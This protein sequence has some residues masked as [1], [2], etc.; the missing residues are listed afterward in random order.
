[1]RN[2]LSDY[3]LLA[4]SANLKETALNSFQTLDTS[5][6][7][8]KDVVI[9]LEQRRED[10]ADEA[11]GKE[12][13]DT[14]YDLGALSGSSLSFNKAQ[15]QHFAFLYAFALGSIASSAYG[16]GYKHVM[17][18]TPAITNPSFTAAMR[19]G[20]TIM[21]I[22]FASMFVDTVKASFAKD[23][24]AKAEGGFKG[25]GKYEDNMFKETVTAAYNA[26][27]L[28][29][30]ANGV[31]GSDAATRL[32]NVHQIRVQVP[33]T[34][35]WKE[36]FYSV[37]SAATP[38][39]LT[40]SAPGGVATS[41]SYEILY[42]PTEPAWCTIPSRVTESPLKVHNLIIKFGGKWDGSAFQGGRTLD[43]EINSIEH[44]INNQTLI[45]FRPGGNGQYANYAMRQGRQQTLTLNREM[46][47][48]I[49]QQR[50][51]DNEYFGVQLKAIGEE[52]ETG[53]NFS[54]EMIF[55]R[56]NI[57]KAPVSING[58]VIAEAGDLK[59]LED[60]TYGSIRVEIANKVSG[61]AV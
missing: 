23:A 11:T 56:C 12:E 19:F 3:D 53:K 27:S 45:D 6:L 17:T 36:V 28:T 9:N 18:P 15:A 52:F 20:K 61:Y 57:L 40:I 39:V 7:I 2:Y 25:T 41:T 31:Q 43:T 4:V 5:M 32:D 38:A 22:R 21:K 58:K 46:R 42:T 10:N 29:L 16:T 55:P 24:W 59:V 33:T 26:T 8:A 37:V 49:L 1:M 60:N 34:G 35:E 14:I 13:P 54:V 47:E 51:K 30:A 50:I 44:N 48:F